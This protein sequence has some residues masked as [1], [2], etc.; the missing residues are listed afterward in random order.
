MH[1]SPQLLMLQHIRLTELIGQQGT[2]L[3]FSLD[4]RQ[5]ELSFFFLF[6]SLTELELPTVLGNSSPMW[7]CLSVPRPYQAG[8]RQ[9][10]QCYAI[11]LSC[12]SA[13]LVS[14]CQCNIKQVG[15][16][17]AESN[18]GVARTDVSCYLSMLICVMS[19]CVTRNL[20][21]MMSVIQAVDRQ[22]KVQYGRHDICSRDLM[23]CFMALSVAA[24]STVVNGMHDAGL[25]LISE[26]CIC[27]S[28]AEQS[29]LCGLAYFIFPQS[30]I[31][32]LLVAEHMVSP[33]P[34]R[35]T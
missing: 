17:A 8:Q 10:C 18:R 6:V 28:A 32:S 5:Q 16:L 7:M 13:A 11:S 27:G 26:L 35:R 14:L 20:L 23:C 19:D 9:D 33:S 15:I 24:G 4:E 30:S 22:H 34:Q 2:I 25:L 3:G 31:N 1:L 12:C 21:Y 29:M